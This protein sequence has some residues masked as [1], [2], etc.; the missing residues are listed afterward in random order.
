M[1]TRVDTDMAVY[2]EGIHKSRPFAQSSDFAP[3]QLWSQAITSAVQDPANW[4]IYRCFTSRLP[5]LLSNHSLFEDQ[6]PVVNNLRAIICQQLRSGGY[7]EP[8]VNTGLTKSH[9]AKDLVRSLMTIIGYHK[10]L[11]KQELVQTVSVFLWISGMRDFTVSIQCIHALG[12]CCY[13]IPVIM[14]SYMD[15]VIDKMAKMVT[16]KMLA[17]H[18]LQFLAGLSRMPD[19]Y[20]NFKEH[21]FKKIFGVCGN[22]LR[23]MR[24]SEVLGPRQIREVERGQESAAASD[25]ALPQYIYALAHHV[26][27]F[28]YMGMRAAER[29]A[30]KGYITSCLKYEG[31]DGR[32]TIE[33]QGIVTIDVMDAM[34]ALEASKPDGE[35]DCQLYDTEGRTTTLH[36]MAGTMLISTE[37]ALRTGR[38]IVDVRRPSG[39]CQKLIVSG[40]SEA[41]ICPSLTMESTAEDYT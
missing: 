14:T 4:D 30:I 11:T 22:Y 39:H 33:D 32:E 26:I 29:K 35:S 23:S 25:D 5:D 36:R 37:T 24:V 2:I 8:P 7:P 12:L 6:T 16:Q 38:T 3:L 1:R 21:D 34:D 40:A 41:P 10:S 15:D 18:V 19:L 9:V 27:S 20:R 13:E 28:W 17:I 31:A